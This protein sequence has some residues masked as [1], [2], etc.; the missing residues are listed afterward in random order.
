MGYRKTTNI[1]KRQSKSY[2]DAL[3]VEDGGVRDIY[4]SREARHIKIPRRKRDLKF[5]IIL[6]STVKTW[7]QDLTL[8]AAQKNALLKK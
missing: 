5:L 2:P 7:V 4:L 1:M 3:P 6:L 8:G